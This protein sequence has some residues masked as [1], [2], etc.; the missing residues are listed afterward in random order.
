MIVA[1]D[2][3]V[4]TAAAADEFRIVAVVAVAGF[5]RKRCRKIDLNYQQTMKY[6]ENIA[7]VVL[8]KGQK[9]KLN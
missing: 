2:D 9:K 8:T 5:G 3:D 7:V 4:G 1:V 6:L